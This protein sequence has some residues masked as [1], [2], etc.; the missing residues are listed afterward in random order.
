MH[1]EAGV[2]TITVGGLPQLLGPMQTVAGSRGAR[3]YE[4]DF[5]DLDIYGAEDLNPSFASQ[6]P[7][8]E[9][10]FYVDTANFNLQDQVRKGENFPLQFA[11]EAAECR[12]YYTKASVFDMSALWRDAAHATWTDPSLCVKYS[13]DHPSST[14][15]VTDTVGPSP[16]QRAAWVYP[17]VPSSISTNKNPSFSFASLEG[18]DTPINDIAGQQGARCDP[19]Q[20]ALY[21]KQLACVQA[22]WCGPDGRFVPLQYQCVRLSADGCNYGQTIGTGKCNLNPS[23]KCNFCKS[24]TPVTSQTCGTSTVKNGVPDD[25]VSSSRGGRSRVRRR[26]KA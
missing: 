14:G 8:R 26:R 3:Y 18:Y 9:I 1:H 21:C 16:A 5:L 4:A 23:G 17:P 13:T 6:L 10:E 12:I 11:Y 7:D 25:R 19:Q 24:K 15:K 22:P 2:K 20:S